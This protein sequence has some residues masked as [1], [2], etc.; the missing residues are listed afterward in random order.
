[1]T[2]TAPR[3]SLCALTGGG[4]TCLEPCCSDLGWLQRFDHRGRRWVTNRF[5]V[6]DES[7]LVWDFDEDDPSRPEPV[8]M[9]AADLRKFSPTLDLALDSPE[10]LEPTARIMPLY[11]HLLTD[12]GASLITIGS[13]G[14]HAVGHGPRRVG[15]IVPSDSPTAQP[16]PI[17]DTVTVV[18]SRLGAVA[19]LT[20][21]QAW[22]LAAYIAT[23]DVGRPAGTS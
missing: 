17:P 3:L 12:A 4:R 10:S 9:H 20:T 7:I 6:F 22:E 21:W 5:W 18:R 1:V 14:L 16:V 11:A 15:A 23:P 8:P 2:T 19:E 13:E